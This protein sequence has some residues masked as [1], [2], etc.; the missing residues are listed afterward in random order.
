MDLN[1]SHQARFFCSVRPVNTEGG[2]LKGVE[3]SYQQPFSFLPGPFDNLGAILNVTL[4]ESRINYIKTPIADSPSL[5]TTYSALS[6]TAYN[7]TL[8]YEDDRFSARVSAAYRDR[9]LTAVPSGTSSNDIDGVRDIVTVDASAS[10]ASE[11]PHQVD[12]RRAESD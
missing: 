1:A 10:Y 7:A 2:P 11:Q 9:Y 12:V 3:I 6:K 5:K 8:Y 4:V